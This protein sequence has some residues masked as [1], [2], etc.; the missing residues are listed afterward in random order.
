VQEGNKGSGVELEEL[1]KAKR[2]VTLDVKQMKQT[3]RMWGEKQSMILK[4]LKSQTGRRK[5]EE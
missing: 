5:Q 2:G 3:V 1:R 4:K